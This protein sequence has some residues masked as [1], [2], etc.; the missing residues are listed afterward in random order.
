M[1]DWIQRFITNPS[2]DPLLYT[3]GDIITEE[4]RPVRGEEWIVRNISQL[5]RRYTYSNEICNMPLTNKQID[6]ILTGEMSKTVKENVDF[7]KSSPFERHY[8]IDDKTYSKCISEDGLYLIYNDHISNDYIIAGLIRYLLGLDGKRRPV[9]EYMQMKVTEKPNEF[10]DQPIKTALV[11]KEGLLNRL[12]DH[13]P[14]P[15]IKTDI[16]SI[17]KIVNQFILDINEN[18]VFIHGSLTKEN[19]MINLRTGIQL[20]DFSYASLMVNMNQKDHVIL[21]E[22]PEI[23]SRGDCP[24]LN[25]EKDDGYY[26]FTNEDQYLLA[27][28]RGYL[29]RLAMSGEGYFDTIDIYTFI[30]SMLSVQE[31]RRQFFS[32]FRGRKY[33]RELWINDE[34]SETARSELPPAGRLMVK[35]EQGGYML[36]KSIVLEYL[37][38]RPLKSSSRLSLQK[39][40]QDLDFLG[41]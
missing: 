11:I 24:I 39:L 2:E 18:Y 41:T 28:K 20:V 26:W 19:I 34:Y 35:Q 17:L 31:Y 25:V 16:F 32:D 37:K 21:S 38:N 14:T 12:E 33:W 30:I 3:E 27:L 1:T 22:L 10:D 23:R 9:V 5:S 7:S 4:S 36:E 6:K 40:I 8:Y 15:E 13:Y 29:G